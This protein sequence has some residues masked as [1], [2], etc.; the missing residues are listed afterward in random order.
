MAKTH[1]NFR[2]SHSELAIGEV[3]LVVGTVSKLE[4]R[5]LESPQGISSD[6]VEF[7]IDK[8]PWGSKWLEPARAVEAAGY[9]DGEIIE[10]VQHVALNTWTN[11]INNV[12]ETAIDF[13]VVSSRKVA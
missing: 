9:T 10:I 12:A 6:V 8:M 1:A 2:M 5:L 7:R 13:P 11:Y 3:P 4:Q